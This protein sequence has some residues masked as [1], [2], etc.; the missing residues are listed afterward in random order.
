MSFEYAIED[1]AIV[2]DTLTLQ[3]LYNEAAV[4]K[5]FP[6]LDKEKLD[7]EI[8][9]SVHREIREHLAM[10]GYTIPG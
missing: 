2:D 4:L 1:G 7:Q 6:D 10:A 8:G 9:A 3:T 5:R